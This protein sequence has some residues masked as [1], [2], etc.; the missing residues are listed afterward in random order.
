MLLDSHVTAGAQAASREERPDTAEHRPILGAEMPGISGRFPG[1]QCP[2]IADRWHHAQSGM[3][4][5]LVVLLDPRADP[6]LAAVLVS[7]CFTERSSNSRVECQDSMT[8]LSSAELGRPIDW[9]MPSP[10]QAWRT[11]AAVYSLPWSVCLMTPRTWRAPPP[12]SPARRRPAARR[13]ARRARTPGRA[14]K[15]SPSPRYSLT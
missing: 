1:L 7:K 10:T 9:R 2:L 11:R 4:P 13:G 5:D 12:L 15:P 6:G 8:A 3:P 14:G